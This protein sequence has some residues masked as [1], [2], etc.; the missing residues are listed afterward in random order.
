[1]TFSTLSDFRNLLAAA[2]AACEG[3]FNKAEKLAFY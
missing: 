2:P 3:S 1:M